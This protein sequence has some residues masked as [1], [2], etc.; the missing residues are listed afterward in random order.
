[1]WTQKPTKKQKPLEKKRLPSYTAP[2]LLFFHKSS[3]NTTKKGRRGAQGNFALLTSKKPSKKPSNFQNKQ[4]GI[5]IHLKTYHKKPPKKK[6]KNFPPFPRFRFKALPKAAMTSSS[7]VSFSAAAPQSAAGRDV[8]RG[9][10]LCFFFF[11]FFLGG[12]WWFSPVLFVFF[13]FC[14]VFPPFLVFY[15]GGSC[16]FAVV[17]LV[18]WV[19]MVLFGVYL[20]F[21]LVLFG[22]KVFK[23]KSKNRFNLMSCDGISL[24]QNGI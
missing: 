1:M 4:N 16:C 9:W 10:F 5:P 6:K 20:S 7:T 23:G 18:Q 3:Q 17:F 11:S 22:L 21:G 24:N 2:V 15:F 13:L 19:L 14:F 12:E 8:F